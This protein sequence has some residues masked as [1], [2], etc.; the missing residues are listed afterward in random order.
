V[1]RLIA[2]TPCAGLLPLDEGGTTL[3]EV[4]LDKAAA[5]APFKGQE[6]AVA[7]V[8]KDA[9]GFGFPGQGR[10][11]AK[12]DVSLQWFAMGKALLTGAD[13]P[14]L[15]GLAAV[16]EQADAWAAVRLEGERA[17]AVLARLVPVDL[18]AAQFRKGQ[19]LRTQL[20]HMSA[21]ITRA[22]PQ[23]FD[24]MVFRSMAR[25]LVHELHVAMQGVAARG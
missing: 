21:A 14:D 23:A 13:A 1:A 22:G 19:T 20:G 11:L 9:F 16:T 3:I 4:V 25:T 17:E 15:A 7:A 24:I 12:G 2:L 10:V 6:K 5:I 8:M 18:R